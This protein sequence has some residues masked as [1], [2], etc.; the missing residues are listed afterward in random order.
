VWELVTLNRIRIA[1]AACTAPTPMMSQTRMDPQPPRRPQR[2]R[3]QPQGRLLLDA[4]PVRR[5]PEPMRGVAWLAA[6]TLSVP[7]AA[8]TGEKEL[9]LTITGP[10]LR[11]G[12]VSELAWDGG[13]LVI[14]GVFV[15]ASGQL[16]AQYFAK[17]AGNTTL[18]TWREHSAA[19]LQYWQ[20]KSNRR[21]PTGLGSI[22]VVSD[23]KLPMYGVGSLAQRMG[24]AVTMGGTITTH[25]ITLHDL[26]LH[27]RISAVAPYDG[28]TWS[29]SPLE[30]NRIAYVDGKGDLWVAYAD[31][32]SPRRIARGD[33]T[34]PA[35]SGDGRMIAVAERKSDR[36]E[37]SVIHLPA[38]LRRE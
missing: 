10:Q 29:W 14:Q 1:Q 13:T 24:D 16:A 26:K 8:Q 15:D 2:R 30:L 6:L 7:W 23:S 31:G 28:E 21:S 38:D 18:Q 17:P 32:R 35:W 12:V 9:V 5:Y 37:I 3:V 34:L 36:W 4:G 25:V 11:S 19:S 20:T 33:F 27:E 22:S